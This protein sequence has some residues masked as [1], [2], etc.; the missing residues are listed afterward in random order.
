VPQPLTSVP[1]PTSLVLLGAGLFGLA[2][3]IRRRRRI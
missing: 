3:G 2:S 1:E